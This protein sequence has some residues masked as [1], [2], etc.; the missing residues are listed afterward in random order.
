MEVYTNNHFVQHIMNEARVH[1]QFSQLMTKAEKLQ[2]GVDAP[3][4]FTPDPGVELETCTDYK[5]L[6]D[7]HDLRFEIHRREMYKN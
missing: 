5:G 2:L 6:S 3:I 4:E 1:S 7:P